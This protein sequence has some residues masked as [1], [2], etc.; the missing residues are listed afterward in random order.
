MAEKELAD[1]A[2]EA[3]RPGSPQVAEPERSRL[4]SQ[5]DGWSIKQADGVDQL[6][7]EYRF[8]DFAAAQGFAA[9]V[10]GLAEAQ[11]HHPRLVLEWG[12]VEVY[13]WTHAIGGLHRTDFVMAARCQRAFAAG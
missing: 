9:K 2:C 12:R 8:P 13:W 1:E 7:A 10:G 6:V 4:L 11:N 3:C 5:L